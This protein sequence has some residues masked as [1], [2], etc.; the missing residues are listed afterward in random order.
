MKNKKTVIDKWEVGTQIIWEDSELCYFLRP[1]EGRHDDCVESPVGHYISSNED[2]KKEIIKTVIGLAGYIPRI[3]EGFN[4]F[5]GTLKGGPI[6]DFKF[7][8]LKKR[9]ANGEYRKN[10]RNYLSLRM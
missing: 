1:N 4:D 7:N 10:W 2:P 3:H 6:D 8:S 9:I 5:Y